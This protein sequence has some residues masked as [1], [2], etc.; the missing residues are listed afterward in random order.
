V[1]ASS[2]LIY[3]NSREKV[4]EWMCR[5]HR[6]SDR[7]VILKN[8]RFQ[9]LLQ[10]LPNKKSFMILKNNILSVSLHP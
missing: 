1:T 8:A 9:I 4:V 7:T 10:F 6:M 2:G 5:V 3:Y